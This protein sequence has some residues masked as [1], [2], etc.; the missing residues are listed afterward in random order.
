[1]LTATALRSMM[2]Q[3]QD[4]LAGSRLKRV[5]LLGDHNQLP[6]VVQNMG[7]QKYSH[8]DQSLFARFV[9]LG[10]PLLQLNM[11]G[12]SRPT[13]A[14]LW[15]WRYKHLGNLPSVIPRQDGGREDGDIRFSLANPGLLHEFQFVNVDDYDGRGEH[16]P[17]PFFYQNL[18][19]AEY[20]VQTY[21]Y[22]R[23]LG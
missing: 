19:E 20:V 14:S 11:Q 9:R 5:V 13:L 12:R 3:N 6:P 22:M 4:P 16:S 10:V 2:L 8:M 7:F 23:L 15:N 18:G 17:S 1:V 21:M